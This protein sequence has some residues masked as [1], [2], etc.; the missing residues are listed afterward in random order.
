MTYDVS[1]EKT[2]QSCML[3]VQEVDKK[4]RPSLVSFS[5]EMFESS[6]NADYLS[7]TTEIDRATREAE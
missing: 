2:F 5:Q 7:G 3:F 1:F 4:C 6:Q